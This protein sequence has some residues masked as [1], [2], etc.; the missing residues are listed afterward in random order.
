MEINFK[1]ALPIIAFHSSF[2][3]TQC[4]M[5]I[6][7]QATAFDSLSQ[8]SSTSPLFFRLFSRLELV[9]KHFLAYGQRRNKTTEE[10][11]FVFWFFILVAK[12]VFFSTLCLYIHSLFFLQPE[13]KRVKKVE[14]KSEFVPLLFAP[15]AIMD[16]IRDTIGIRRKFRILFNTFRI[17]N[18]EIFFVDAFLFHNMWWRRKKIIK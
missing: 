15:Q 3:C 1:H 10:F 16:I 11:L 7:D 17:F 9:R 13:K 5:I 14:S 2:F 6:M 18:L 4:W 8:T 12:T